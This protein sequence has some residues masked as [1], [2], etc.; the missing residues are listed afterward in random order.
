MRVLCQANEYGSLKSWCVGKP[1]KFLP[2]LHMDGKRVNRDLKN[3]TVRDLPPNTR[4]YTLGQIRRHRGQCSTVGYAE[5][6]V[7]EA[8][9]RVIR[10]N[11][12]PNELGLST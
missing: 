12:Q 3:E 8:E 6:V 2:V 1:E 9:L 10:D 4:C 7:L 5:F 11:A